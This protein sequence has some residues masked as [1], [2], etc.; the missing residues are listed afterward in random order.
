M[1]LHYRSRLFIVVPALMLTL[2]IA[3]ISV[4]AFHRHEDST[5]VNT[6][7]I[8]AFQ[9]SKF[10]FDFTAAIA[11]AVYH[12]PVFVAVLTPSDT[13]DYPFYTRVFASHAPPQ[14]C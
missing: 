4:S 1:R 2:L 13:F 8:C 11:P 3:S 5:S 7:A 14:F 10:T 12:K 9:V 6:C